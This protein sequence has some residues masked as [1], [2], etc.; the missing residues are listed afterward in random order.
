ME[1]IMKKITSMELA[2]LNGGAASYEDCMWYLQY[3]SGTH[4]SSGN[5]EMENAYWEEWGKR[6]EDCA[7]SK[8]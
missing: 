7:N 5:E 8:G 3:E 2:T 4:V 1:S 6:F